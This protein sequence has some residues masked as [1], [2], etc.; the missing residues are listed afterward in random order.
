MSASAIISGYSWQY[1]AP[2]KKLHRWERNVWGAMAVNVLYLCEWSSRWEIKYQIQ[3]ENWIITGLVFCGMMWGLDLVPRQW[4]NTCHKIW[5]TS[6]ECEFYEGAFSGCYMPLK[7]IRTME[8][9]DNHTLALSTQWKYM[10][11][12]RMGTLHLF[13]S[14]SENQ[15]TLRDCEYYQMCRILI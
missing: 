15:K 10:V 14:Q 2:C 12:T 1:S 11:F 9:D 5:E 4:Q 6:T 13:Q 8:I 7:E 3:A